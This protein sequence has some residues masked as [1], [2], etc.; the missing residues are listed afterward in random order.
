MYPT[1]LFYNELL[2]PLDFLPTISDPVSWEIVPGER[3]EIFHAHHVVKNL[4]S[5]LETIEGKECGKPRW[6]SDTGF[7]RA[8]LATR[9]WRTAERFA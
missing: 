1:F 8:D 5:F 4:D 2:A 3:A 9:K 7:Y 6:H